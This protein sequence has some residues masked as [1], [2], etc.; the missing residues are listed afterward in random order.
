MAKASQAEITRRCAELEPL[1]IDGLS[2]H[3][4]RAFAVAKTAWGARISL[5]QLKRYIARAKQTMRS[6][7]PVDHSYEF[8]AA[9]RRGE[10][11]L[12]RSA[13]KGDLRTYLAANAQLIDLLGLAAPT[14]IEC[15]GIDLE[16]ARVQLEAEIAEEMADRETDS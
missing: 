7:A 13:A 6:Q 14:R 1:L 8:V 5:S 12:A 4:I 15:S 10:R 2:L 3:E 16:A 9:K 11:A